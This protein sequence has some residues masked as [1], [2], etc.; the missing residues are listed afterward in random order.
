[1]KF[2]QEMLQRPKYEKPFVLIPV[3]YPAENA[4]IPDISRKSLEEIMIVI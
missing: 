4:L 3:G 2:L 1:M